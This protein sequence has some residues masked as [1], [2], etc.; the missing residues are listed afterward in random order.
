MRFGWMVLVWGF[1]LTACSSGQE[2]KQ[3]RELDSML[4]S[5]SVPELVGQMNLVN[6]P[7]KEDEESFLNAIRRGEIGGVLNENNP[8]RIELFQRTALNESPQGIPL[9]IGRDVIHGF[10]LIFPINLAQAASWNPDLVH[11]AAAHSA[12]EASGAG[13]N[14]T[15][16]PMLD[17]TRDPRWGRVAES[18]GEDPFLATQMGVAMVKAYQ[19]DSLHS[20]SLLAACAKHFAAYGAVEGGRDY[21]TVAVPRIDL[22]NIHFRPFRE[23]AK[24]SVASFMT[25]FH[26][27]NGVPATANR[28]LVQETLKE[29]WK[30][31]GFVVSDWASVHE[32]KNHGFAASDAEAA[33]LAIDAGL[34]MEMS[35]SC[36]SGELEKLLAEGK[37][38]R[39]QLE[40]SVN[41]ILEVKM[42]MGLFQYDERRATIAQRPP[43]KGEDLARELAVQSA[44]LLK[45]KG[46]ILPLKPESIQQLAL[47][48]PLADNRYEQL[49]TWI[50]DGDTL[51]TVTP[52]MAF[53]NWIGASKLR[54]EKALPN[55]RSTDTRGINAALEAGRQSDVMVV[56][57]GEE[58]ILSG[59]AHSRAHLGL[60]GAQTKLIQNLAELGK[61]IVLVVMA[62]RPLVLSEVEPFV[63]AILYL[64]HPGSMGGPALVDLISGKRNPSGKLPITFPQTEGQIPIYYAHKNTG[65][66][67]DE[68]NHVPMEMIPERLFQTSLPNTNHYLDIGSLPAYPFGYGLSYTEYAYSEPQLNGDTFSRSDTLE[69]TF[70]LENR[71]SFA[72]E[73]IV[74]VYFRDFV[75]SRTRPVKELVHFE[76]VS[77][78]SGEEKQVKVAL[79][80]QALGFYNEDGSYLLEPGE[81][82]LG[83][84]PN[85]ASIQYKTFHVID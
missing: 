3:T 83:V 56:V 9:L 2:G 23:A 6:S 52:R 8:E 31:P 78:Q 29:H 19:G 82:F 68:R 70:T 73:E 33:H 63:E 43:Q 7:S 59:E 60:P 40:A 58:S 37:I 41:R 25:A 84:G 57:V 54:Y 4:R 13:I 64:W 30:Y 26:E 75:A 46:Q 49:G 15:F 44:V 47:I 65:R 22:E 38:S 61:P 1:V 71:G 48:G 21:N 11:A 72:G 36:Y 24:H 32:L 18:F 5:M 42:K 28:Y 17:I 45:N 20:E 76:R 77:L 74:Q 27:L 66:P 14:W 10:K 85:A 79:P 53:A 62:G 51:L 69:L 67:V 34:D 80:V 50:F 12:W 55:T 35:G 16:S 81:F 39:N